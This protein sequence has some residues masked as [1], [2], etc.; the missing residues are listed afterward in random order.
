MSVTCRQ[1]FH[2]DCEA[3]INKQINME[4]SASYIYHALGHLCEREDVAFPGLAKYFKKASEEE[5]EHADKFMDYQHK[6]GGKI[7]YHDI[8]RP[9]VEAYKSPKAMLTFALSLERDVNQALLDLHAVADKHGDAQMADFIEG[10]YLKEQVEG[11]KELSDLITRA[12]RCG[13]GLGAFM[14][15]KEAFE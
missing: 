12:N 5:R 1:N 7:V 2:E 14:F 8:K 11:E 10:E 4:L 13:D 3:G 6:R 9:D 15:D